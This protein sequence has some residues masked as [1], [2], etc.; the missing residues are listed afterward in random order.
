MQLEVQTAEKPEGW[1]SSHGKERA[2]RELRGLSV[3]GAGG[4]PQ[5]DNRE[6]AQAEGWTRMWLRVRGCTLF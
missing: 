3:G 5:R 6:G 2:H 1:H 4:P